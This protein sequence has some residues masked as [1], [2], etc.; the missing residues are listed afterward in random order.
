MT[1]GITAKVFQLFNELAICAIETGAERI[2]DEA[3]RTMA[4]CH[5]GRDRICMSCSSAGRRPL[6]VVLPTLRDE[7]L[8]GSAGMRTSTGSA[9]DSFF[10]IAVWLRLL[11]VTL[12]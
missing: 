2:T 8:S 9:A 11:C 10:G 4:P 6:P 1:G 3:G 12:T 7:L 5:S